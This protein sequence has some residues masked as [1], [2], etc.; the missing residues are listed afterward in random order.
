MIDDP[1]QPNL[2]QVFERFVNLKFRSVKFHTGLNW[3]IRRGLKH[4]NTAP[5]AEVNLLEDLREEPGETRP[6]GQGVVTHVLTCALGDVPPF[7]FKGMHNPD[8]K[9][10]VLLMDE[11]KKCYGD[12]CGSDTVTC[13]GFVLLD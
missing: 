3:T 11:L 12:I 2:G 10:I 6:V 5:G 1:K 9:N 4:A 7:V 13:V 8:F